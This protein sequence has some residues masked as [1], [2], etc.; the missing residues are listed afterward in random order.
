M[1]RRGFKRALKSIIAEL[2]VML[3]RFR[4]EHLGSRLRIT[5]PLILTGAR[6]ITIGD[7]T[8]IEKHV[9]LSASKTG[10]IA[11]GSKCEL[12]YFAQIE[13]DS[14]SIVIGDYSS[15]NPFC[16]LN[17]CGGL[18]IGS[19]V[20]I[21]SHSVIVSSSHRFDDILVPIH[22]QGVEVKSTIIGDDVWI[23][24]HSV[25]LGGVQI[26]SHSI[27]GA[28]SVVTKDVPD[29]AIVVGS[30]ARIIRMRTK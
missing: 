11:I 9:L 16:S 26:G 4:F 19:H 1:Q 24:A 12:G 18:V 28:G 3:Y 27:V 23:G 13:T 29:Y 10:H 25:I 21:A 15:V 8:R 2:I 6:S 22:E 30:P 17:G 5:P 20:R 14:G 7:D